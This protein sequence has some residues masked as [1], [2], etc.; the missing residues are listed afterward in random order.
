MSLWRGIAGTLWPAS[1]RVFDSFN[2]AE[3]TIL[4][5]YFAYIGLLALFPFLIF[6]TALTGF[7]VGPEGAQETLDF[8][9]DTVPEHVAR[10]LEPVIET[11][12]TQRRSGVLTFSAL[13]ALWA[14]A[15][16][17]DAVR[18]GFDDAYAVDKRRRYALN[19]VYLFGMVLLM[20]VGFLAMTLLIIFAPLV[21]QV[22]DSLLGIE[23]PAFIDPVRYALGAGLLYLLIYGMHRILP[24]RPMSGLRLWPGILTS[25]ILWVAIATGMSVYLSMAPYYSVTYGTLAGVIVTLLF[26]YLTGAA[27]L[28]GAHVNAVVNG[29]DRGASTG[30]A[31]KGA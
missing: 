31:A 15:N 22:G 20:L 13:G 21:F 10:T 9:F 26:F 3:A 14:S 23:A 1:L 6:A 7:I 17:L 27:L 11:I 5:G 25:A 16:G 24:S 28:L 30:R 8:L 18:L 4:A 12:V 19:R 29:M 2:E